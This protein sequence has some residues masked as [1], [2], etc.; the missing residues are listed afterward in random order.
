VVFIFGGIAI[1]AG[2]LGDWL[3]R[4]VRVQLLLNRL[5]G[6]VFVLLALRLLVP[7]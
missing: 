3:R 7:A 1:L 6:T 4:S 2:T 5:A